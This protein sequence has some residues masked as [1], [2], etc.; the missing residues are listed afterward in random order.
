MP[1]VTEASIPAVDSTG[2]IFDVVDI[3]GDEIDAVDSFFDVT[4]GLDDVIVDVEIPSNDT[5]VNANVENV[6][7][8][9]NSDLIESVDDIVFS[10]V[11][12]SILLV[13]V[14]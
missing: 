9:G 5:V 6:D 7:V 14:T 2:D 12:I 11:G 10:V 4:D 8:V 3:T 13:E 1:D